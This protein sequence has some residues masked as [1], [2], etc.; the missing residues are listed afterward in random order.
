MPLFLRKC[1]W[2]GSKFAFKSLL[3]LILNKYL[4]IEWKKFKNQSLK[5]FEA[6]S[7]FFSHS[8]V[9]LFEINT[10]VSPHE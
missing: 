8:Q 2:L 5:F 4:S 7:H 10:Y 3:L 6:I 9:F 1:A